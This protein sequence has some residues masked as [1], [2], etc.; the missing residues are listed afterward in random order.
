M[1]AGGKMYKVES[2]E[3]D[4]RK[5]EIYIPKNVLSI[6]RAVY[7]QDSEIFKEISQKL[8]LG[9]PK[10]NLPIIIALEGANRNADYT[11]WYVE[12]ENPKYPEFEGK[13]DEYLDFIVNILKPYVELNYT[14]IKSNTILGYSLGGLFSLYAV[15][16][17]NCF[18]KVVSMS[19]SFW[20]KN[21]IEYLKKSDIDR[22]ISIYLNCGKKE[23]SFKDGLAKGNYGFTYLTY[24]ILLEKNLK[25]VVLELDNKNHLNYVAERFIKAFKWIM[26]N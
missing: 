13:A 9:I 22:K 24:E 6:Q 7:V 14:N 8:F 1:L 26:Q 17:T 21:W 12:P 16:K 3:I 11:P 18:D 23:G 15:T 2:I 10:E 25:E 20:Y 5:I 4:K 19:G